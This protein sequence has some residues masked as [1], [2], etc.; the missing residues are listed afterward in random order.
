MSKRSKNGESISK[1]IKSKMRVLSDFGICDREDK[2]MI[3]ELEQAI[4]IYPN[5]PPKRGTRLLLPS[6][7][8]KSSKQLEMIFCFE[9]SEK[10]LK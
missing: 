9:M 4:K 10:P 1:L 6:N 7:D 3:A 8:P 5:K 2:K